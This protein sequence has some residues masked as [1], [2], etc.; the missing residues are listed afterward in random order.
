MDTPLL[1]V[2]RDIREGESLSCQGLLFELSHRQADGKNRLGQL[3]LVPVNELL[4]SL[5]LQ[6]DTRCVEGPDFFVL[7]QNGTRS[8]SDLLDLVKGKSLF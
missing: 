2:T 4:E 5:G 1:S 6:V 3:L 8:S 7:L